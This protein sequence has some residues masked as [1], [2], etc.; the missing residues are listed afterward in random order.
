MQKKYRSIQYTEKLNV[1]SLRTKGVK[2]Q[3]K[4]PALSKQKK[5]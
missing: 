3:E 1:F 2:G 5:G 4:Y